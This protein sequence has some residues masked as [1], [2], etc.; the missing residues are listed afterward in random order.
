MPGPSSPSKPHLTPK[1]KQ[2]LEHQARSQT[3]SFRTV[4]RSRL[5]LFLAE[6]KSVSESARRV[7]LQRRIAIKWAQRF[8]QERLAGLEDRPRV[9]RPPTFSPSGSY[10]S[11]K[12]GLP[13]AR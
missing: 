2:E 9:G 12:I 10:L 7:G 6:G 11:S 8:S 1:E 4:Q 5:I 13:N 3:L